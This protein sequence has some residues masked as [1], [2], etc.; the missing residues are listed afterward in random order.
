MKIKDIL[1]TE[2]DWCKG[3]F[4][5]RKDTGAPVPTLDII[6]GNVLQKECRY[7]LVGAAKLAYPDDNERIRTLLKMQFALNTYTDMVPAS[8][9]V[10]AWNDSDETTFEQVRQLIEDL[11]L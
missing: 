10:S 4:W 7:C 8:E 9:S 1:K 2:D 6:E 5:R 3:F 11:D